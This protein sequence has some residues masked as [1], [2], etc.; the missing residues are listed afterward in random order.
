MGAQ[1]Q[2]QQE[3]CNSVRSSIFLSPFYWSITLTANGHHITS[4][5]LH[6]NLGV[7]IDRS[8][9]IHRHTRSKVTSV[10]ALTTNLLMCTICRE[11]DFLV[12][13]YLTHVRPLNDYASQIW[14]RVYSGDLKLLESVQR[15]WTRAV[16]CL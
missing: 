5:T 6:S 15:R 1:Y 16:R 3:R 10:N 8:L 4:T 9:K 2:C 13:L 12:N 14:N 7:S 11:P